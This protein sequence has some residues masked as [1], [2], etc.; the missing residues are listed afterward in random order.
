MLKTIITKLYI[1]IGI[2]N[3]YLVIFWSLKRGY[4]P[5]LLVETMDD[6]KFCIKKLSNENYENWRY[7]IELYLMKEGLL[8][9]V[10]QPKPEVVTDAWT[11]RD[12]K[13]RAI[14]GLSIEDSQIIHLRGLETSFEYWGALKNQH[15][16]N[17]LSNRVTLLK[18]ICRMKLEDEGNIENYIIC[19]LNICEKLSGM[20]QD[21]E[22]SLKVALL[23]SGLP[24]SYSGV[25]MALETRPD[26]E[27]TFVIVKEKLIQEENRRKESYCTNEK[28]MKTTQK[29]CTQKRNVS[30]SHNDGVNSRL[31]KSKNCFFCDRPGH[32]KQNCFLYKK[33]LE[34][35]RSEEKANFANN[36]EEICLG[37]WE[38]RKDHNWVID[39]AASSHMV[40]N[41]NFFEVFKNCDKKIFLADGSFLKAEGIGSGHITLYNKN[42]EPK[43][44]LLN[45]VLYIPKLD[46][47]LL[48]VNKMV[49]N[50]ANINFSE[51]KCFILKNNKVIG[52]G[53]SHGN[54]YVLKNNEKLFKTFERANINLWHRRLGH[55]NFKDLNL[56]SKENI[57]NGIE[58]VGNCN[59]PCEICLLGKF[60]KLQF[61]KS[62]SKTNDILELV[63][64]DL[65]GPINVSTPSGNRFVLTL[66]DDFSHY[67]TIF[68]LKNK[69]D[70]SDK[71]EQFV[72][73]V[74]NKFN[75][76]IKT[77]RS[78]NGGEY[79]CEKLNRFFRK[80]GIKHEYTAP[81]TPEQNGV[82]ERMN[83]TL[84]EM[85]RCMLYESGLEKKFWGEA[86]S[87]A[88]YLLNRLPF[89]RNKFTPYE[90]WYS[91]KPDL[92][93]IKIFGADAFVFVPDEK[94]TKLDKKSE[95]LKL[96]G[97][98]EESKAYR[99]LNELTCKI[100]ISRHVKFI[101]N[102]K[103][104]NK[105]DISEDTVKDNENDEGEF[106]INL[107]DGTNV[108]NATEE[109]IGESD[110]DE[111]EENEKNISLMIE[112]EPQNYEKMLKTNDCD[113]W[114]QAMEEEMN[115]MYKNDVWEL[116][117]KK[118]DMKIV[119]NR[120]IYKIKKNPGEINNI[121]R[122][123][124]VAKG[125][126]Q[127]YGEDYEQTFAP[128]VQQATFRTLLT[129]SGN[130]NYTVNH[131]DVKTAFLN[132]ILEEN[133]YMNQPEGFIKTGYENYVCKLK[134]ALYGLK[135]AARSWNTKLSNFLIEIGY[136]VSA[137]DNCLFLKIKGD[138]VIYVLVYVDDLIVSSNK[139]EE[140]TALHTSLNDEFEMKN[141]GRIQHYLGIEIVRDEFGIFY[142][143][144][145]NYIEKLLD[146]FGLK[147]AKISN[148]PMDTGYFKN[149]NDGIVFK[150]NKVFRKAIGSLLY[151]CVNT[152]PDI[153]SSVIILSRRVEKPYR[154]DW[155]EVKRILRYLKGT[156]NESLKFGCMSFDEKLIGFSDADWAGDSSDRKSTSG[157]IIQLSGSTIDW[158]CQK[159]SSVSLSSCESEYIALTEVCKQLIWFKQLLTDMRIKIKKI[160][161]FEDNQSVLKDGVQTRSKHIDVRYNFVKEL[162][163]DGTMFFDYC[164]TSC[165][166]A[167]L[168]TKP[169]SAEKIKRFKNLMGLTFLE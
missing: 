4:E 20:G 92:S 133:V 84:I 63:H 125:Y 129:I 3:K 83:R 16:K 11:E 75:K 36:E 38:Q 53:I 73:F 22:K 119:S 110:D 10:N 42:N 77:F 29:Y 43:K 80:N 126:T 93:N 17:N 47:N 19:F 33:K 34:A 137:A 70:V 67:V 65:C 14:I 131:F 82:A 139:I 2:V 105:I 164:E 35:K 109:N 166:P 153:S 72:E 146:N 149:I 159:Q 64:S 144:Q 60:S 37:I 71:I 44:C 9:T 104:I 114:I 121:Y 136:E 111:G 32:F 142:L 6:F 56:I 58:I 112:S 100:T 96:I 99:L 23:L 49:E 162:K 151:L 95:K 69:S 87:T 13:A 25:V 156:A 140:I 134:K 28:I 113:K 26:N 90:K 50:G 127:V 103:Q 86:I 66:I 108:N 138:L 101:E 94:R 165:M 168:L 107:N 158:K 52:I 117:P 7:K 45:N 97:Y 55:R 74:K 31:N 89:N 118:S 116:V 81:Y 130:K 122:A 154:S 46:G 123:R 62:V 143:N 169:L 41:K 57:V 150:D 128:V 27:L 152:R 161:V 15:Q 8:D 106:V 61:D 68:L 54:I 141:L 18:K 39:S 85:T 163:K 91:L 24:E 147:D 132:G 155:T 148:I 78:D 40:K 135:Q 5:R 30:G 76:N 167:D 145:K 157:Y 12:K 1:Y 21:L 88:S 120:W 51:N 59:E 79:I 124:L 115:C 102:L 98:S 48:S 160:K